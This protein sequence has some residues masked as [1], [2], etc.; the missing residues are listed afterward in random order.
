[1]RGGAALHVRRLEEQDM[2]RWDEFVRSQAEGSFFHL[3]GWHRVMRRAFGHEGHFL[4]AERGGEIVAV[5]PLVHI[6][7]RLFG[8][9]LISNAFCVYGGPVG[10]DQEAVRA[11]DRE[12]VSLAE[13]LGVGHLEYRLRRPIHDPSEGWIDRDDL[14]VTFRKQISDDD[15]ANL[16]AIPRKQR[17]VVR[18][19]MS[20][21]LAAH[22]TDDPDA[23]HAVYAESVRN[24]GTPVFPRRYFRALKAEFGEECGLMLIEEE[25]RPVAAC[26]SFFFRDEVLP[27]YGGGTSRAR[28]VGG[29][30][31]LYWEIMRDAVRRGA[32]LFDFGRSKVGTGAYNFKKYWGFEPEP[33]HY[34][35][36]LVRATKLPETNPNNPK[37]QHAIALWRRLPLAVANRIGPVIARNLG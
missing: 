28:A 13:T 6:D 9:S 5:L 31:L 36:R 27:Y 37:Y 2:P 34:E 21:G 20:L 19:A 17:A 11:L 26:L 32:R 23:V 22:G 24:L 8:R 16:K 18:K 25:G 3:S 15:E 1:M 30:D 33:L 35:S 14:Y 12:A 29:N 10:E 7:S 4:M